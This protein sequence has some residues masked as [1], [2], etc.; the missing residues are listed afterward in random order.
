[1]LP[2]VTCKYGCLTVYGLI[3]ERFL[4]KQIILQVHHQVCINIDVPF[5]STFA[6]ANG[7]VVFLTIQMEI[8]DLQCGNLADSESTVNGKVNHHVSCHPGSSIIIHID[9]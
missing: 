5:S 9:S 8:N 4:E 7:Q 2:T 3:P 1:M 6:T